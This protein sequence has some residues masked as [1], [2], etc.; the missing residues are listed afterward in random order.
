[1]LISAC[2]HADVQQIP[3]QCQTVYITSLVILCMYSAI[4]AKKIKATRK[5]YLCTF[6]S[7]SCKSYKLCSG[8]HE[9]R[10]PALTY[11]DKCKQSVTI[12]PDQPFH[13][14]SPGLL[15]F[16]SLPSSVPLKSLAA[17]WFI[18]HV[19]HPH[20]SSRNTATAFISMRAVTQFQVL[21]QMLRH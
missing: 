7:T 4:Y 10:K 1:M 18:G 12:K 13:F 14:K 20:Q 9:M 16:M 17:S 19:I 5:Q 2:L 15:F 11:G 8:S 21:M 3:S 6:I